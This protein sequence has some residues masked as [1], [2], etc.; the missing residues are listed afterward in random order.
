VKGILDSNVNIEAMDYLRQLMQTG[1]NQSIN[2]DFEKTIDAI[3]NGRAAM[4][5]L[6]AGII[7]PLVCI[8]RIVSELVANGSFP[9]G[10]P[11]S[12]STSTQHYL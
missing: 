5:I 2:N 12:V 4:A 6:W 10:K 1:V 9:K 3:C 11:S 7:D 8:A